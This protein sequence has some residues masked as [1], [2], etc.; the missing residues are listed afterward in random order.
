MY[1]RK[2]VF[3][4]RRRAL[5]LDREFAAR[6]HALAEI[7]AGLEMRDVLAGQRYGFSRFRVAANRGGRKCN[8]SYDLP[9][10]R[11]SIRCPFARESLIRSSRC[12]TASSTSLAGR[13]FLLAGNGFYEF[14]FSLFFVFY[15]AEERNPPIRKDKLARTAGPGYTF[16]LIICFHRPFFL[17]KLAERRSGRRCTCIGFVIAD[18]LSFLVNFLGFEDNATERFLRS[19]LV[20]LASTSSPTLRTIRASSTRP[21]ANSDARS[22]PMTPSPRSTVANRGSTSVTVPLTIEFFGCS[23]SQAEERILLEL[24]DPQRNTLS[25]ASIARTAALDLLASY[26]CGPLPRPG[27]PRKC[28]TDEPG[29]RC[30]RPGR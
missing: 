19:R 5:V 2:T 8:E 9:K 10:P 20:N 28:Q 17:Q 11:I 6:V 4:T 21:R 12:L 26:S 16:Y 30:R 27:F 24:L 18:R 15:Y 13:C 3:V 29:H 23:A 22:V 1:C 14:R 7:L 25:S